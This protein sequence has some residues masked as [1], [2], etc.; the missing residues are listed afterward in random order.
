[1]KKLL[2][3]LIALASFVFPIC[4]NSIVYAEIP[5]TVRIVYSNANV[6]KVANSSIEDNKIATYSYNTILNTIGDSVV[7]GEDAFNYYKVEITNIS[8]YTYGFVLVSQVLD[9]T[10]QSPQKR[11]DANATLSS[12]A[13][14][15]NFVE[16]RYEISE[17][18][19]IKGT[20]VKILSGYDKSKEYT[21]I[22]Y[23]QQ[24]GEI[25]TA[26]IKTSTLKTSGISRT[27]IG[28]IIII[29]TVISL[30]LIIFGVG[31]K[32]KKRKV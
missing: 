30:T 28:A 29:I 23:Q 27:L 25:I 22:Q 4:F 12:D 9:A 8:N 19:L 14:V 5:A 16:N 2:I 1:M 31:N 11:L 21:Q 18:K 32:H 15:Y 24:D 17:V 26:F 7:V 6:Y 13:F 20:D 3:C 10:I